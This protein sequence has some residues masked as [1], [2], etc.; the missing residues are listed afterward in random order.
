MRSWWFCL[1]LIMSLPASAQTASTPS[2]QALPDAASSR[3][4]Q[5]KT[6]F[7]AQPLRLTP[8]PLRI[9]P[10]PSRR[11]K[12]VADRSF[13]LAAMFQVGAAIADIESTQYG[14]GHGARELNPLYGTHPTRARQY[15]IAM[16][17]GAGVLAWSY[18]LKRSAPHS[19]YWLIPPSVVG[20]IH[21][22]AVVHN[23][24]VIKSR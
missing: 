17:I 1:L 21:S 14:L 10:A 4:I 20:S 7:S 12:P 16:P 11:R 19:R 23:L 9:E 2:E 8:P 18:R 22:A 3:F 6:T 15:A 24:T 5:E 13:W